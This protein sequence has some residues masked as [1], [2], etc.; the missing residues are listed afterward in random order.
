MMA[1][2]TLSR[3][4]SFVQNAAL[5]SVLL[6]RFCASYTEYH[7]S[8]ES[9]VMQLSFL[10][11]PILLHKE[12]FEEIKATRAGLHTFVDKF[13]RSENSKADILLSIHD[14]VNQFR[15]LTLESIRLAVRCRLV[16]IIKATSM[17][18]PLSSA[19]PSG[20]KPPVQILV[21]NAEKLG[22]WCAP[23]KLFEIENILKVAF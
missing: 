13:S 12:T 14:R 2:P 20:I 9:P 19:T 17:V 23:M 8:N 21:K 6:W 4:A 15:E 11:L 10:V 1:I 7:P 16:T 3:E 18:V 22:E 5:G